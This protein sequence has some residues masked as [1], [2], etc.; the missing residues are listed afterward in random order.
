MIRLTTLNFAFLFFLI[1]TTCSVPSDKKQM[2]IPSKPNVVFVLADQ[3]R[4]QAMGYAGNDVVKTPNLDKLAIENVNFA[5]AISS[6]AVCS[7]ARASI[8][9]GEYPLTHGIFYNDKPLKNGVKTIAEVFGDHGYRTGYIGKW[10]LNGRTNEETFQESRLKPVPED[11]R[12]G[13]EY[14]KVAECT[15]NY[16]HSVYFDENN[17]K[18]IWP[19]YDARAQTDSAIAFIQRNNT[20]PFFLYLSWG[21][22]HNPY[23]TAP[24]KYKMMY[25]DTSKIRLRPNV[26]DSMIARAKPDIA[27]YYAHCT[28]LDDYIGRLQKAVREVGIENN[29]IFIFTSDHGDMLWSHGKFAKQKPWDESIRVPFLLKYPAIFDD[30]KEISTPF[31]TTDIMPTILGLSGLPVPKTVEGTDFTPFLL[32]EEQPDIKAALIMCP[33]PFHEWSRIRGGREYRG[34]RTERY[35]YV[36]DLNGPWLLYDNEEDPY[37]MNNFVDDPGYEAVRTELDEELQKLLKKTHDEFREADYYMK[38]WGY[39]YDDLD[40]KV[41]RKR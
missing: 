9:S 40:K 33:V 5:M 8:M 26:P 29:T 11:R 19:G 35:T 36:R 2:N 1:L 34:V 22:P 37:Q 23:G 27:G 21:P 13:F 24:E 32:N 12:Q 10:H 28:A 41:F 31:V 6:C 39:T 20:Q 3:W 18:H 30:A 4:A 14:W 16:N 25:S 38:K 17:V 7:P 15:H